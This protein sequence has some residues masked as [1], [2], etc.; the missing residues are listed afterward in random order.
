VLLALPVIYFGH[1]A[2]RSGITTVD[3]VAWIALVSALAAR[4]TWARAIVLGRV[5]TSVFM[6]TLHVVA[7]SLVWHANGSAENFGPEALALLVL[8]A[9][10]LALLVPWNR[11]ELGR[12]GIVL[13]L[14]G[15]AYAAAFASVAVWSNVPLSVVVADPLG[16]FALAAVIVAYVG[17]LR[18]ARWAS[19]AAALVAVAFVAGFGAV[20][21]E[22]RNSLSIAWLLQVRF[23]TNGALGALG[24]LVAAYV[25]WRSPRSVS[26]ESRA[27][28]L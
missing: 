8:F 18:G 12:R 6:Q 16:S 22:S 4:R 9:A 19:I 14:L 17:V 3:L 21:S 15:P 10:V 25:M 2:L 27:R 20:M 23:A 24:A 13:A 5:A 1:N 26:H 7:S 28:T 11:G